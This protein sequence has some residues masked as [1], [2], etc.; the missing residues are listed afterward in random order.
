MLADLYKQNNDFANSKW[1][2]TEKRK[3]IFAYVE[4]LRKGKITVNADN[5]TMCGNPYALLLYSVGE[6]WEND[7]CFKQEQG[8]IQ[9]YTTRFGDGEYLCGIRSPQNSP[10]NICYLKNTYSKEMKEYFPFSKNIVAVNCIGTDLQDRTNGSDFDSDFIFATNNPVMVRCAKKC[11]DEFPTIVNQ[12]KE[13]SITYENTKLAYSQMDNKFAKSRLGIG[14]SS[15]LAQL[16]MT[17]YWTEPK[18][19]LYDNFVILSVVA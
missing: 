5:L 8:T 11:Y 17:Y 3:I 6:H 12:L 19:E 15:N 2:R 16:A 1:F 18:Q 4:R 14:W 13:S 9:C 7:P 10:N